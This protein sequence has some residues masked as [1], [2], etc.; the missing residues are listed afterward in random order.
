MATRKSPESP[1]KRARNRARAA[2]SALATSAPLAARRTTKAGA[3]AAS[4]ADPVFA[5]P[6]L[7][8]D[9]TK[10]LKAHSSD[11]IAY[12]DLDKLKKLHQFNPLPF[13]T[14]NTNASRTTKPKKLR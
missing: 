3:P 11:T 14:T 8:P 4:G 12:N 9:P 1:K 6:Q 7:M 5:E 10:F 2:D 13:R